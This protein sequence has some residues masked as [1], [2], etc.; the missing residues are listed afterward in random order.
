MTNMQRLTIFLLMLLSFNLCY[1]QGASLTKEET[2]NYINKK[3]KEVV[4]HYMTLSENGDTGSRLWHYRFNRLTISSDNKVKYERMRSNYSENQGTVK[5]VLGRRYT[6]YPKDYYEIDHIYS[7]S[8]E[9][10]I[11]IEEAPLEGGRKASD[12]VSN[13]MI[14]LSENTGL[15]E[16]GVGAVT[17]HF[18]D[19]YNDYYTNFERKLTN[20]DQKTTSR[21]YISYLKGDGSNFNKIKKALE[22]L[23]SLVAAED[24]PFGD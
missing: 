24:D 18:T 19:D 6:V 17:N 13:M 10:I 3:L 22:Y 14:I 7:F 5:Y 8:P 4:G 12:P 15:M 2:V 1:S 9:N 16:R 11:S 21:V 20:P 23:K